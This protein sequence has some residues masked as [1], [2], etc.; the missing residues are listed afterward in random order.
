MRYR[1]VVAIAGVAAMAVVLFAVPL[2]FVLNQTYRD[3]ELLKLQR[4]A[5]EATRSVDISGQG[6]DPIEL[7]A[8]TDR[9]TVYGSRGQELAGQGLPATSAQART[10]FREARI[11][12]GSG[13][14]QFSVAVP[15]LNNERVGGV[16]VAE[17]DD[18]AVGLRERNT[19]LALVVFAVGLVALATMAALLMARHLARPLE[20]LAKAAGN[21]DRRGLIEGI[22]LSGIGELDAIATALSQSARRL[23][24]TLARERTFSADASHQMRTPLAALRI[25]LESLQLEEQPPEQV[26]A[27]IQQVDRLQNTIDTLLMVARDMPRGDRVADLVKIVEQV[28]KGWEAKLVSGERSIRVP[29]ADSLVAAAADPVVVDQVLYVLV[30]NA[31]RHGSGQ[32]TITVREIAGWAAID[33]ADEGPGFAGDPERAFG[34]GKSSDDGHGIGLALAR[35]LAEAEGGVSGSRRRVPAR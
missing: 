10:A 11:V 35:S 31:V 13:D 1:L 15:L 30:E 9:L 33:V 3:Q 20:R 34:R 5:V 32:V 12:T 24:E 26:E 6:G 22:P 18:S 25:E 8:S 29:S 14:G 2:G 27:A 23:E 17:R 19:W 21:V 28:R 4:D 7:P 16:L